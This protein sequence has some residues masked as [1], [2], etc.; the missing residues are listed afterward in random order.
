MKIQ[1]VKQLIFLIICFIVCHG[2]AQTI[3]SNFK[4]KIYARS[5]VRDVI[6]QGD[7]KFIL[8]GD[9][10]YFNGQ[11]AKHVVRVNADWSVDTSFDTG[12]GPVSDNPTP[13]VANVEIQT[14]GKILL[15]G[16]FSS[17]NG[18]SRNN[19]VRL[20]TNGSVDETFNP[21]S[22]TYEIYDNYSLAI[23]SDGKILY[24]QNYT[25]GGYVYD[26]LVRL[27]TNGSVDESFTALTDGSIKDVKVQADGKVLIGGWFSKYNGSDVSNFIRVNADGTLENSFGSSAD[28]GVTNLIIQP[29]K[30]IILYG[31]F[32]KFNGVSK[33][34]SV[35]ISEAGDVDGT[36]NGSLFIGLNDIALDASGKILGAGYN[37]VFRYNTD[38]TNDT[39]FDLIINVF[40]RVI[41]QADSK[42]LAVGTDTVVRL[43]SNMTND[44]SFSA[45]L[46]ACVQG[47]ISSAVVQSDGK[48]VL[49]G[50]FFSFADQLKNGIVRLNADLSVDNTFNTG[51]GCGSQVVKFAKVQTDDK[52][53]L[54]GD[55]G[56]YNGT[57]VYYLFRLNADGTYDNSY[58]G[59]TSAFNVYTIDMQP[60]NKLLLGGE[61]T[62]FNS[63]DKLNLVR[64]NTDGSIDETFN[65]SSNGA[66]KQCIVQPDGGVLL[67]GSFT[68]INGTA[69]PLKLARVTSDGILDKSFVTN[70]KL[71]S[72]DILTSLVPT[73]SG[74]IIVG[75]SL[76]SGEQ[77]NAC[78]ALNS[79]GS[80]N[81][82][83]TSTP[84]ESS[85][86]NKV[87]LLKDGSL[88]VTTPG[89]MIRLTQIT[90]VSGV[91]FSTV[92][93]NSDAT[94]G[95]VLPLTNSDY[96]IF[97]NL[98]NLGA[99]SVS[100]LAHITYSP[101]PNIPDAPSNLAFT[102]NLAGQPI[103]SWV[104]NADN[105][106]GFIIQRSPAEV[107][108]FK[109]INQVAENIVTAKDNSVVSNGSYK[110][111]VAAFNNG[112]SSS[113]SNVLMFQAGTVT[114]IEK[115]VN[116]YVYPNPGSGIFKLHLLSGARSDIKIIDAL[117]NII[118]STQTWGDEV[119]LDIQQKADGIYYVQVT[120][121]DGI[122]SYR[123]S[124]QR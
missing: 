68:S 89:K 62:T 94:I 16:Q 76:I 90:G 75:G 45:G 19:I 9:F 23:N 46:G 92:T 47:H 121:L 95:G 98:K 55:V 36:F 86:E 69:T 21:P 110:Y 107:D 13:V 25:I 111:R 12:A 31:N 85:N 117:G 26:R 106:Q 88:I 42:V 63:Q 7:G 124:K 5:Q 30:K 57:R 101:F 2:R 108:E 54:Y 115:P 109:T 10:E 6:Q 122:R 14:D 91:S 119:T 64:L 120:Q 72:S 116:E 40:N 97:G 35:R 58:D 87:W 8:V 56:M 20:N 59:G 102:T 48:V 3:D 61:F 81:K 71:N 4:P 113:F 29:D 24:V 33:L 79:D 66:I 34:V 49:A 83:F 11:V 39:S 52:I 112:G 80:A 93:M 22:D 51:T 100:N 104:D 28:S 123:I 15:F 65:A 118:Y 74:S 50:N 82:F 32:S 1:C 38:G 77:T 99:T 103:L 78:E 27:N 73:P 17:F 114:G 105:E 84:G 37:G 44:L 60:D 96:L 18:I 67:Y 53:I 43:N 70:L 41:V